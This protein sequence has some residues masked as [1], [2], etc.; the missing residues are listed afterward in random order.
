VSS[1][2]SCQTIGTVAAATTATTATSFTGALTGDISGTQ[3][4]T[5][6][7]KLKG[8]AISATAPTTGQTLVYNGTQYVPTNGVPSYSRVTA[9]QSFTSTTVANAT[10]LSFSAVAGKVYKYNFNIL[11]TSAA[12]GT[13]IKLGLTYPAA[14]TASGKASIPIGADGTATIFYGLI[15]SS[16]D[17]VIGTGTPAAS[18]T[19]YATV[20]GIIIPSTTGTVQLTAGTEVNA[21]AIVIKAGSFVEVSVVP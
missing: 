11:Y 4:A 18:T 17:I 8:V 12:T 19:T 7:D 13:G 2:F 1:T 10:S 6:V 5:S 16:G 21:S 14:T 15:T 9:D 3:A 20:Q